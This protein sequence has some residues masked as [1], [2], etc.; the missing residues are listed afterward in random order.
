MKKI[1]DGLVEAWHKNKSELL[2]MTVIYSAIILISEFFLRR[3]F[4]S[5]LSW[6]FKTPFLF[7][8]NLSLLLLFTAVL[9]MIT[10]K[11]FLI[12]A[13]V[14]GASGALSVINIM[15]FNLR[16]IPVVLDDLFLINEVWVLLPEIFNVKMII[17]SSI[18]LLFLIVLGYWANRLLKMKPLQKQLGLAIVLFSLSS[19]LLFMGGRTYASDLELSKD[20][21][22]VV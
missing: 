9:M 8:L 19:M 18:G 10:K 14:A 13:I 17:L 2:K 4:G 20:R 12:T 11:T 15:K 21:K 1:I 7:V 6:V 22:S 3:S 16:N 5:T